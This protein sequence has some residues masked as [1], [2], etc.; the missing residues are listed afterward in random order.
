[1]KKASLA[2]V[3]RMVEQEPW[4]ELH[5][6]GPSSTISQ[7]YWSTL[8]SSNSKTSLSTQPPSEYLDSISSYNP[9]VSLNARDSMRMTPISA[10]SSQSSI[11]ESL[12]SATHSQQGSYGQKALPAF[13]ESIKLGLPLQDRVAS[14]LLSSHAVSFTTLVTLFSNVDVEQELD[15]RILTVELSP[16]LSIL[17][18]ISNC[19]D[20]VFYVASSMLYRGHPMHARNVF[21]GYLMQN[22][23]VS[24]LAWANECRMNTIMSGNM[25]KEICVFD[26]FTRK[27]SGKIDP[28]SLLSRW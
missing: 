11:P 7:S 19:I 13:F 25:L 18:D 5:V 2:E 22:K 4:K 9:N 26:E 3:Q 6:H 12:F 10:Q 21:L 1:M 8:L 17:S 16:L 28:D 23:S 27:W 14:L 20:G 15:S 24:R